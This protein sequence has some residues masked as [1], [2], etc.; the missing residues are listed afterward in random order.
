MLAPTGSDK[1]PE[2]IGEG[3]LHDGDASSTIL[4]DEYDEEA[5]YDV[6]TGDEAMGNADEHSSESALDQRK[7]L[8]ALAPYDPKLRAYGCPD[9]RVLITASIE[10]VILLKANKQVPF[11]HT[12]SRI[13]VTLAAVRGTLGIP[14]IWDFIKEKGLNYLS[15]NDPEILQNK[16]A[17]LLA[18]VNSA[19]PDNVQNW[20]GHTDGLHR[21]HSGCRPL[22]AFSMDVGVKEFIA[23][24]GKLEV[25][26]RKV[27]IS[28]E[29]LIADDVL[30]VINIFRGKLPL[31]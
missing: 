28:E 4:I 5:D 31:N 7:L 3:V 22:Q 18:E 14:W 26:V 8:L 27:F 1:V 15:D 30:A 21:M 10:L 20:S 25:F 19:C 17:S 11:E 9:A 2:N 6:A 23:C 24:T 16:F 13:W 12:F 29:S